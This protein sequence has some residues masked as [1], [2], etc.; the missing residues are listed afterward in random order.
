MQELHD[1]ASANQ[2]I[3]LIQLGEDFMELERLRDQY[4]LLLSSTHWMLF[5][6]DVKDYGKFPEVAKQVASSSPSGLNLLINNAGVASQFIKFN[7]LNFD[8]VKNNLETNLIAP[9][10]LTKV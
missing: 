8:D 10:F 7:Q 5:L 2:D 6:V 1:L 4:L 9:L 3:K